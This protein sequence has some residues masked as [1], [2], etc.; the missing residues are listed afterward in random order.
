MVSR[1]YP[2]WYE[3]VTLESTLG[4]IVPRSINMVCFF[5]LI[6]KYAADCGG[7][8]F[9]QDWNLDSPGDAAEALFTA[10]LATELKHV[11]MTFGNR[12]NAWILFASLKPSGGKPY[13]LPICPSA[14]LSPLIVA[15]WIA[16]I[17]TI[18]SSKK[19]VGAVLAQY[20]NLSACPLQLRRVEVSEGLLHLGLVGSIFPWRPLFAPLRKRSLTITGLS[21]RTAAWEAFTLIWCI[22]N[23]GI[24]FNKVFDQAVLSTG[25]GTEIS[26]MVFVWTAGLS[27]WWIAFFWKKKKLF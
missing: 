24:M 3:Q 4:T 14:L 5:W 6:R 20:A 22:G 21:A 13:A 11:W 15:I 10:Y 8:G 26:A 27:T 23:V 2:L 12:L 7:D 18:R 25:N 9:W 17:N 19:D 16:C 1:I